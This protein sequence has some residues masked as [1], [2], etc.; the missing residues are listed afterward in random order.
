MKK[1]FLLF[2]TIFTFQ[3]LNVNALDISIDSVKVKEN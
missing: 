2:I 1:M 3:F